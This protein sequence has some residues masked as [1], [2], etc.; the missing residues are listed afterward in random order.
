[1]AALLQPEDGMSFNNRAHVFAEHGKL[2]GALAT[3]QHAVDLGGQFI[4]T[5]RQTLE[6]IKMTNIH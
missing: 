5:F 1:V 3:A 4:N 2:L 6:E